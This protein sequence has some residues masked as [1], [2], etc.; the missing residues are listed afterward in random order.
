MPH[1]DL[2]EDDYRLAKTVAAREGRL[3]KAV[4]G[5]ALQ[6]AYTVPEGCESPA[7]PGEVCNA[8]AR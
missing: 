7:E 4:V 1:I 3:L 2:A 6:G 8:E 5:R